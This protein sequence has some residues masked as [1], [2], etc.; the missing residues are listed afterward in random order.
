MAT[1]PARTSDP[2]LVDNNGIIRNTR[3]EHKVFTMSELYF[4]E[5]NQIEKGKS[6]TQP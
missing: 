2:M 6:V 4:W 3:H 5:A 1:A